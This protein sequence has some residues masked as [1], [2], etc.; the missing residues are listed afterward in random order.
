MKLQSFIYRNVREWK[1]IIWW[2][3]ASIKQPRKMHANASKFM[4][5]L[6][7]E[8]SHKPSRAASGKFLTQKKAF[9]FQIHAVLTELFIFIRCFLAIYQSSLYEIF[10]KLYLT[11]LLTV[12]LTIILAIDQ[13]N[14]QILVSK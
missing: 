8:I 12:H 4:A 7:E 2:M 11:V 9:P 3:D 10:S 6:T 5:H 1:N 13:L 14:V